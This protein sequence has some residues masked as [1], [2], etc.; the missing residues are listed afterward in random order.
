M[1]AIFDAPTVAQLAAYLVAEHPEAVARLWG[2]PRSL[3]GAGA[4]RAG[5]DRRG[6]RARG[7]APRVGEAESR[8]SAA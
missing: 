8:A 5:G 4:G 6:R 2:A 3:G 1:V 7:G